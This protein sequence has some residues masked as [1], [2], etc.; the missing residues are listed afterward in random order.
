MLLMRTMRKVQSSHIHPSADERLNHGRAICCGAKGTNY[1]C[2]TNHVRRPLS[3]RE[4][5]NCAD[6]SGGSYQRRR[7]LNRLAPS[8]YSGMHGALGR[9]MATMSLSAAL[10]EVEDLENAAEAMG[11][12]Y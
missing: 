12:R 10:P 11:L 1:L 8:Q 4:W 9:R 5:P 6:D 7:G 3:S 2:V